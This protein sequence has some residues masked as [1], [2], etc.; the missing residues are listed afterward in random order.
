MYSHIASKHPGRKHVL[1]PINS[2]DRIM[3]EL[4]VRLPDVV[5]CKLCKPYNGVPAKFNLSDGE[6]QDAAKHLLYRS[7]SQSSSESGSRC[8]Q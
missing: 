2:P 4:R 7:M 6:L 1:T 3:K 5:E 8:P